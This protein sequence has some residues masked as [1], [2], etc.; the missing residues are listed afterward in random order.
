MTLLLLFFGLIVCLA[1]GA[2]TVCIATHDRPLR[3]DPILVLSLGLGPGLALTSAVGFIAL[4]AGD[5]GARALLSWEGL[6]LLA[7]L[8]LAVPRLRWADFMF[9]DHSDFTRQAAKGQGSGNALPLGL[10]LGL[11]AAGGAVA[12]QAMSLL[13][14]LWARPYGEFDAV[15]IWN[16]RARFFYLAPLHW[17]DAF[18]ASVHA[19]YPLLAP[20]SVSRLW[21]Y[22]GRA[23][24]YGPRLLALAIDLATIGLLYAALRHLRGRWSAILA[25]F[26]LIALPSLPKWGDPICGCAAGILHPGHLLLRSLG[27]STRRAW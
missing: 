19:D 26:T 14:R 5:G 9:R 15:S 22:T 24:T 27:G 3:R 8:A 23:D 25:V 6:L 18:A 20:L 13:T 10:R 17:R 12:V 4:L 1:V 21:A 11:V 16:V 2:L 7:V